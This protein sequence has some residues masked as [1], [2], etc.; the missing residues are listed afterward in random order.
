MNQ[1]WMQ[2]AL[3]AEARWM[4]FLAHATVVMGALWPLS[5]ARSFQE[6]QQRMRMVVPAATLARCPLGL[7]LRCLTLGM[8]ICFNT[9][10]LPEWESFQR[11]K[12]SQIMD[13][14]LL[15]KIHYL[16]WL[17][18]FTTIHLNPSLFK[19]L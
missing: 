16:S 15:L 13:P 18:T 14:L 10:C 12:K 19:K 9:V 6:A 1:V 17:H 8:G 3:S 7:I 11:F 2:P 5:E 4:E